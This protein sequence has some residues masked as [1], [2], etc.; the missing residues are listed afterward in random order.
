MA[1]DTT[2]EID[3]II[4]AYTQGYFPMAHPEDNNEIYWHRPELRGIIPL[5][6]FN[7]GKNLMRKYKKG[8]FELSIN[9]DFDSVIRQ[10]AKREETWI[11]DEI[12]DLYKELNR[13][14][15][16]VSFE[17]WQNNE[18]AGGL[19][20]ITIGKA[21][22]GESMFYKVTDA[23]KIAL[24]FLVETLKENNYKLLD[25]QYLNKHTQQ[26]GGIE[27]PD[28]EYQVILRDAVSSF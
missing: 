9:K 16:A 2:L 23:S 21:F 11:S 25:I 19:Y 17:A 6:G 24:V 22:F 5:E 7:A 4:H 18:L 10:C 1:S 8:V 3:E 26:F 28:Q 12:I 20:G 13:R 15:I 14:G 27:I